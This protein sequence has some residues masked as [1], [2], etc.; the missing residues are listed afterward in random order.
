MDNGEKIEDNEKETVVEIDIV[1]N[2]SKIIERGNIKR[3]LNTLDRFLAK[4]SLSIIAFCT[5]AISI[6]AIMLVF[7]NTVLGNASSSNIFRPS[8]SGNATL[9]TWLLSIIVVAT[10][11]AILTT[12]YAFTK[13][14]ATKSN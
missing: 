11:I 12:I 13:K 5:A 10:F 14:A 4:R 7:N 1:N 6:C 2:E 8:A 9:Q 3:M